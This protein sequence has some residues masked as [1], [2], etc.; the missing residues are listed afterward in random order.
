LIFK[1]DNRSKLLRF[2]QLISFNLKC[3]K[4]R[5]LQRKENLE[6]PKKLKEKKNKKEEEEEGSKRDKRVMMIIPLKQK[7][8]RG[9]ENLWDMRETTMMLLSKIF[10][11]L[12][13]TKLQI[14]K[15]ALLHCVNVGKD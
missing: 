8:K 4:M 9:L 11:R 7:E 15:A 5:I 2:N 3:W 6:G 13:T 1:Q 14:P 10:H 12:S